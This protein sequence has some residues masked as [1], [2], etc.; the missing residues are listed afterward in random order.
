M[1]YTQRRKR[2]MNL[3]DSLDRFLSSQGLSDCE[4]LADDW[5]SSGI[6]LDVLRS[7]QF[8]NKKQKAVIKRRVIHWTKVWAKQN[9]LEYAGHDILTN[10]RY[11]FR[12]R[13]YIYD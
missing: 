11:N 9:K 6:N 1:E 10:G 3:Q 4:P 13:F 12:L 8:L 2:V 5:D 7:Q